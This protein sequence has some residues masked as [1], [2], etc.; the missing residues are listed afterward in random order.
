MQV[1]GLKLFCVC[2]CLSAVRTQPWPESRHSEFFTAD[3]FLVLFHDL[4]A[5]KKEPEWHVHFWV[6]R[7][8]ARDKQFMAAIKAVELHQYV[9]TRAVQHREAE[10]DESERF[11]NYFPAITVLEGGTESSLRHVQPFCAA[12]K[13]WRV[14][15]RQEFLRVYQVRP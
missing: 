5:D 8:S 12:T 11:K 7:R 4:C 13:L 10:G 15:G 1:Q 2:P 14:F 3:T 9:G 6:G